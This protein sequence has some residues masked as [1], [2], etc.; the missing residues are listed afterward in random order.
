MPPSR[1]VQSS[2]QRARAQRE[3]RQ[4]RHSL[5]ILVAE[6]D[7]WFRYPGID[8]L[9]ALDDIGY[10]IVSVANAGD[11]IESMAYE[12]RQLDGLTRELDNLADTNKIPSAILISGGGNDFTGSALE[13]LLNYSHPD[14]SPLNEPIIGAAIDERLRKAYEH[15]V[16]EITEA[17]TEFFGNPVRILIHGYGHPVPD[18]RGF[19]GGFWLLPGPWLKPAF[20]KKGHQSEETNTDTMEKL[21]NRFNAMLGTVALGSEYVDYVDVRPCLS[22]ATDYKDHWADE[23][24]P[25]GDAFRRIAEAFD[26]KLRNEP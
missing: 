14:L 6:G 3:K 15:L 7:S 23:L 12:E 1:R 13:V 4:Q 24:H 5:G 22:N 25:T 17:T 26:I 18:G 10:D 20:D 19:W 21:V 9:S 8:V 11:T 16:L 2:I